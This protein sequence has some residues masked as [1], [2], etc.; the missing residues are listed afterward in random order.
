[1]PHG[2]CHTGHVPH[3]TCGAFA[4]AVPGLAPPSGEFP[5][6]PGERGV[7]DPENRLRPRIFLRRNSRW[8]EQAGG[9][10]LRKRLFTSGQNSRKKLLEAF[11]STPELPHSKILIGV[12]RER[13]FQRLAMAQLP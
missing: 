12:R 3:G 4:E 1:M 6:L 9:Y 11:I 13:G 10:F 5:N 7:D 8:G 2:T